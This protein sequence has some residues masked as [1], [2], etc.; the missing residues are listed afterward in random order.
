MLHRQFFMITLAVIAILAVSGCG[1]SSSQSSAAH[2]RWD[3]VMEQARF[4]AALES[5]EQGRLE[6]AILLLEDL[7]ESGSVYS[8]QASQMLDDLRA[9]RQQSAQA[10]SE[11][12]PVTNQTLVN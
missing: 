12:V 4:E 11:T 5:I 6:Y 3:R 2:R 10:Y 9:A 1:Q 7:V 8:E